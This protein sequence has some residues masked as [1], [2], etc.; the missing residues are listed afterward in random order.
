M[1]ANLAESLGHARTQNYRSLMLGYLKGKME[2]RLVKQRKHYLSLARKS[3][4]NQENIK[5][6]REGANILQSGSFS[7]KTG[8]LES[9]QFILRTILVTTFKAFAFLNPSLN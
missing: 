8:R 9:P 1:N 5:R 6:K 4:K 7:A 3:F 2:K